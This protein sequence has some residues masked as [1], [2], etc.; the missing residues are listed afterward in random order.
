MN[1]GVERFLEADGLGGDDVHQRPALDAGEHR[2]IEVLGELLAAEHHAAARPAQ[3]L[4]RGRRDEIGVR[5]RARML[6]GGDEAGD[7]RHVGHHERADVVGDR[8]DAREVE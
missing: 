4:V 8:A 3:R 7:V 5:H 1:S 2:A 6:A